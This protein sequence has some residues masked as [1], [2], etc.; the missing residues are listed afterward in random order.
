MDYSNRLYIPQSAI[1]PYTPFQNTLFGYNAGAITGGSRDT[2]IGFQ[3]ADGSLLG[4]DNVA[5]GCGAGGTTTG[6]RNVLVG[7]ACAPAASGNNNVIVGYASCGTL[8]APSNV[9]CVGASCAAGSNAGGSNTVVGCN[10]SFLA[11]AAVV[12]GCDNRAAAA[13]A[14]VIGNGLVADRPGTVVIGDARAHAH[15]DIC[16]MIRGERGSNVEVTSSL[17]VASNLDVTGVARLPSLA[18]SNW[19]VTTETNS[20]TNGSDLVFSSRYNRI[21]YDDTFEPGLL[22]FTGQHRCASDF[23]PDPALVGMLVRS[24]GTYSNLDG[25]LAAGIDESVPVVALTAS[26]EDPAVF[27]VV[28]GFKR[29]DFK[30]GNIGFRIPLS[31]R[32]VVNSV[33]E[34]GIWVC[35]EGGDFANGDLIVSSSLPGV[36]CRQRDDV[37]R[38]HTAAK[39]TCDCVFGPDDEAV[40][41]PGSSPSRVFRRRFVGCVYKC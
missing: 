7:S 23:D 39:I 2:Y 22:N 29:G 3:A 15:L 11:A 27:G 4:D 14:I 31:M 1:N 37:V 32:T 41:W 17:V 38:S 25:S 24:K 40:E 6:S 10:N 20:Y 18:V 19:H 5:V 13:N 16:G 30:I 36:G 12:I 28:S 26:R 33:G 34:G 35:D 9:T 21:T 8:T